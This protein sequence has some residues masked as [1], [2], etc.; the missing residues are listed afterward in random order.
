MI[1]S[2]VHN[3]PNDGFIVMGETIKECQ[4]KAMD[5]L[6][7]R[8]WD[9]VDCYSVPLSGSLNTAPDKLLNTDVAK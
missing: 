1:F 5:G 8:G 9:M 7:L 4:S 3:N 2:I 6:A